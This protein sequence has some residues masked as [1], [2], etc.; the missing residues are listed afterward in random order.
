MLFN[1]EGWTVGSCVSVTHRFFF[2]AVL[3]PHSRA[4]WT[5]GGIDPELDSHES[6]LN[7][8]KELIYD[9]LKNAIDQSLAKEPNGGKGRKKTVQVSEKRQVF[10]L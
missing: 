7:D 9:K 8:F 4:P 1:L 6:Y 2:F 5:E 10:I 3:S